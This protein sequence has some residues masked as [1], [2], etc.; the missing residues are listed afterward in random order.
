MKI[1][2][3]GSVCGDAKTLF[4]VSKQASQFEGGYN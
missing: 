1:Q 4:I 3:R 2:K